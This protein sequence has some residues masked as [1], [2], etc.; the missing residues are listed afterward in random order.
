M[1]KTLIS[2]RSVRKGTETSALFLRFFGV[3]ELFH[4][5]QISP[6]TWLCI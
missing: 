4:M 1:D 3:L 6:V 5:K 2:F